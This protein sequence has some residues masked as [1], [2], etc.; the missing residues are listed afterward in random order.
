MA[1]WMTLSGLQGHSPI[2][3]V[4]EWQFSYI[5]AAVKKISSHRVCCHSSASC[6]H[7]CHLSAKYGFK[8]RLKDSLLVWTL[9]LVDLQISVK[10]WF[11]CRL[12]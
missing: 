8:P 7:R 2:A 6:Y 1:V 12:K 11:H 4:F 10:H 5:S 3:D 9:S